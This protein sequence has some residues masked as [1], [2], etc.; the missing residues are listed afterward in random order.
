[1]AIMAGDDR[2]YA[3]SAFI[4]LGREMQEQLWKRVQEKSGPPPKGMPKRAAAEWVKPGL[5]GRVR[6]L[7]GEEKLRHATLRDIREDPS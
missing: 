3:G 2:Q 7:K 6:Y 1:M 4:A 5:A